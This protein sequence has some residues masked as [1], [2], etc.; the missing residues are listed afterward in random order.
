[1]E[2]LDTYLLEKIIGAAGHNERQLLRVTN[3]Q[4][5]E[6]IP[7]SVLSLSEDLPLPVLQKHVATLRHYIQPLNS[8]VKS[9]NLENIKWAWEQE[10]PWDIWTLVSAAKSG[11][12]E[13]LKWIYEKGCPLHAVVFTE[14]VKSGNIEMTEWLQTIGCPTAE[15]ML[16][17]N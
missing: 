16:L 13:N 3:K 4:F 2:L 17:F 8:I 14:A 12:L 10:Y 5:Y 6:M 7:M 9:G 1:M 15:F 11:N